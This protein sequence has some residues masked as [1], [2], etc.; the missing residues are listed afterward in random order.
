MVGF[1]SSNIVVEV[2]DEKGARFILI[3]F[4]SVS[5]VKRLT[6]RAVAFASEI[7]NLKIT[8]AYVLSVA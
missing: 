1:C 4:M 7:Y 2:S 3:L 5:R 6:S 8:I